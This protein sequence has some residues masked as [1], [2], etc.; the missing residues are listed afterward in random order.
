MKYTDK[1]KVQTELQESTT[2][3]NLSADHLTT[4]NFCELNVAYYRENTIR[5]HFEADT[6]VFARPMPM[7][8]PV[9]GK[10]KHNLSTYYVPFRVL[11]PQ[12][13]SFIT[14]QPHIAA[15]Y[16]NEPILVEEMPY[17]YASTPFEAIKRG[18][19]Y[20]PRLS[21]QGTPTNF[22]FIEEGGQY[23]LLTEKGRYFCKILNQLGYQIIPVNKPKP[24][25]DEKID[26]M[27]LLAFAKVYID[28]YANNQYLGQDAAY[29]AIEQLFAADNETALELTWYNLIDIIFTCR[30]TTYEPDYFTAAFDR[31]AAPNDIS[32]SWGN[33]TIKDITDTSGNLQVGTDQG[34]TAVIRNED[35]TALNTITKYALESLKA[36]QDMATRYT[37]A[38]T[39]AV[40]RYAARFGVVCV[41]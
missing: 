31:P 29:N 5:E 23:Y 26:A 11:S 24:Q 37:L 12:F 20:G 28:W 2:E 30:Y 27:K 35:T 9:M 13:N 14:K 33:I 21:E 8:L 39:R 16:V 6:S 17:F 32:T 15:G 41:P 3:H 18:H 1:I 22:D 36:L 7:Q 25:D 19:E 40:D 38:G 4:T 34:G 10:A